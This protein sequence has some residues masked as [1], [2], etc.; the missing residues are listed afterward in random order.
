MKLG[1]ITRTIGTRTVMRRLIRAWPIV[2]GAVAV[3]ALASTVRRKGLLGGSVD[4]ALNAMPF[5][6]TMK[7]L[8]EARRGCDF[9]PVRQGYR[10]DGP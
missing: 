5:V 2:G 4:T 8:F 9:I 3:L 7:N 10:A 1:H 6:G